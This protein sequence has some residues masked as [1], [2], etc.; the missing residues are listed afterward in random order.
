MNEAAMEQLE[1]SLR[2]H[3]SLSEVDDFNG[4]TKKFIEHGET[5]KTLQGDLEGKIAIPGEDASEDDRNA[6]YGKL[7]RPES[8]DEYEFDRPDL[9]EG[10]EYD[11]ALEGK[12]RDIAHK[13]GISA[14]ALREIDKVINEHGTSQYTE[15][16][17]S[18]NELN[19]KDL[20]A[21]KDTWK[22]DTFNE[23]SEKAER[24][25]NAVINKMDIP[26]SLG[27]KEGLIDEFKILGFGDEKNINPKLKFFMSQMFDLMVADDKFLDSGKGN[28]P[29]DVKRTE[30]GIPVFSTYE[31]ME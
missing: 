27:G 8:P 21:L 2:G 25:F 5:I 10:R 9:P 13:N 6:F 4:L 15:L 26:E 29:S 24:A 23:N 16:Q 31:N 3:E 17:K 20:N 18:I 22:G 28:P 11:K 1:E 14:K 30:S 12:I 19:E 7:G